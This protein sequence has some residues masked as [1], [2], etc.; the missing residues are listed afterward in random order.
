MAPYVA[1]EAPAWLW[2]LSCLALLIAGIAFGALAAYALRIRFALDKIDDYEVNAAMRADVIRE[3]GA[4]HER[5]ARLERPE[6]IPVRLESPGK[7][8]EPSSIELP[9]DRDTRPCL[10][11]HTH[12]LP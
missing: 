7:A 6:P 2:I 11:W 5:L 4:V 8:R 10:P 1:L 3:F 12:G 9:A